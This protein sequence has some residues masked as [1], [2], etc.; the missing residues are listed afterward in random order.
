MVKMC[1]LINQ[2]IGW[3]Y[4]AF[5]L[6]AYIYEIW[7]CIYVSWLLHSHLKTNARSATKTQ[8]FKDE[9]KAAVYQLILSVMAVVLLDLTAA[10]AWMI[11]WNPG[12][13]QTSKILATNIGGWHLILS[14][15]SFN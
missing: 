4:L 11:T 5:I 2:W 8:T 15:L 1:E 14:I 7:N 3:S 9:Y 6:C 12:F 10:F 13:S